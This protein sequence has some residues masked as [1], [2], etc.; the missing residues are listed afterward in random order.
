MGSGTRAVG[1]AGIAAALALAAVLSACSRGGEPRLMNI[2]ANTSTPD[3]FSILPTRPL[4]MPE[5][6][7]ALPEPTPGGASR[8]DPT[9]EADAIRTL[10]GNPAV[11]AAPVPAGDSAVV[12]HARRFGAEAG[13]RDTLAAEDLEFRRRND[14]RLLE[15]WFSVNVYYRA[16][17]EMAL[18]RYAELARWRR[19]G[20]RTPAA[21]P[22]PTTE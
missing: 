13:I 15:R 7:S 9:P 5:D 2:P 11:R 10:G 1:P 16:Y 6:L 18:D 19:A 22:D 21:P 17:R 20:I 3:E 8:T 4:M 12:A 14:G